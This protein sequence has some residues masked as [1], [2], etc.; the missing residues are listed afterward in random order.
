MK[1]ELLDIL[2]EVTIVKIL[3]AW[4]IYLIAPVQEALIAAAV[5]GFLDMCLGMYAAWKE[6]YKLTS[7]SWRRSI[8][9]IT[10][11]GIGILVCYWIEKLLLPSYP[12]SV[13][14]TGLIGLVEGKSIFENLYRITKVDLLKIIINKFQLVYDEQH[15]PTSS[16][17]LEMPHT[18]KKRD[19][20][21]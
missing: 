18:G 13:G 5:L 1:A 14:M 8:S 12:L 15:N 16:K 17:D 21:N 9:K 20:D 19:E 11:Y 2:K 7:R 3:L 10:V 4:L 6:G